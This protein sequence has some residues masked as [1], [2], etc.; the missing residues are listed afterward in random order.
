MIQYVPKIRYCNIYLVQMYFMF[1]LC[2]LFGPENIVASLQGQKR[3]TRRKQG[4]RTH[5]NEK[6]D[7]PHKKLRQDSRDR[8]CV[9]IESTCIFVLDTN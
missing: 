7:G 9:L 4:R 5:T 8:P 1:N 2:R 6:Y 3:L